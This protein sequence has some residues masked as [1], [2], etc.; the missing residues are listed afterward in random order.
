MSK[1]YRTIDEIA[2]IFGI[3]TRAAKAITKKYRVD[4]FVNKSRTYVH[5]KDF[6]KAYTKHLN[7]SLFGDEHKKILFSE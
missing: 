4:T 1:P 7:P 2:S 5:V 6:Y 3:D